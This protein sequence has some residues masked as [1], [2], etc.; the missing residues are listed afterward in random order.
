MQKIKKDLCKYSYKMMII[1]IGTY[2]KNI[3][4]IMLSDGNTQGVDD[5][6]MR[7]RDI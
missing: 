5:R 3:I 2:H 4:E 7:D 6:M 1:G